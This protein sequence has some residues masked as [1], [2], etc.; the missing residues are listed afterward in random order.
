MS[1]IVYVVGGGV[2]LYFLVVQKRENPVRGWRE[3]VGTLLNCFLG[4]NAVVALLGAR[5][6]SERLEVARVSQPTA[7][8]QGQLLGLIGVVALVAMNIVWFSP[9]RRARLGY[10][11]GGVSRVGVTVVAI[12]LLWIA[13]AMYSQL[14]GGTGLEAGL[15]PVLSLLLALPTLSGGG[16]GEDRESA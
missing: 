14:S 5:A 8:W 10:R 15:V 7:F 11:L 12:N 3:T 6:L 16:A 13:F 1:P 2:F 4:A 9:S